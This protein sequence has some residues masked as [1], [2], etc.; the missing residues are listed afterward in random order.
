MAD[1]AF[2]LTFFPLIGFVVWTAVTAAYRIAASRGVSETAG[3]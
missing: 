2:F 3:A 1:V